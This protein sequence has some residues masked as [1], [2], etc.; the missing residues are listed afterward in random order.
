M[1]KLEEIV[2]QKRKEVN[3][4]SILF[5]T[6]L[7]E[8]S[9]YFDSP[10]VS[11]KKYLT[12]KEK[13]GIIGEFKRKSPSKGMLN[14]YASVEK[15]SIGYMQAGCSALSVLTDEHFFGGNNKDLTQARQFNYCPILRKDFI[16]DEYQIVEAR[17]IG[18]D[19][20][21]LI[22]AILDKAQ[23]KRL[24]TFAKSLNLEIIFEV[25]EADEL[26]NLV[27]EIDIVGVNN[28]NLKTFKTDIHTSFELLPLIPAQYLKISESGIHSPDVALGLRNAGFDGLLIGEQFMKGS[29]PA[30]N[31]AKFIQ[32]LNQLYA[33]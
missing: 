28:R 16:I 30:Q 17:S 20:I 7:L 4:K 14:K 9:I 25:H 22:A 1:T 32:Q 31:C 3:E 12:R 13:S 23:I 29:D 33:G 11:M 8:Q 18:A 19:A 27:D 5:P 15:T 21:L 6:Q 10:I 24:A 2:A 26:Q